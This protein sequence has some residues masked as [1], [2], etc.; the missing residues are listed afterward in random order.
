M[1]DIASLQG[2]IT[3]Q[4]EFVRKLKKEGNHGEELTEGIN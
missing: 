4:G 3:K 1:E 2:Q